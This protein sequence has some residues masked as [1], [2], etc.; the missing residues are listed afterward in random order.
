MDW[1]PLAGLTSADEGTWIER[2]LAGCVLAE[3]LTQHNTDV[4]KANRK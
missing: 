3:V 1:R 4:A 2:V